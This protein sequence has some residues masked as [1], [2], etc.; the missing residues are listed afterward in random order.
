MSAKGE[1]YTLR[2]V[3]LAVVFM[4]MAIFS[5]S[6][7]EQDDVVDI[8]ISGKVTLTNT[9]TGVADITVKITGDLVGS[10]ITDING[11]YSFNELQPGT[12]FLEPV[13]SDYTFDPDMFGIFTESSAPDIDFEAFPVP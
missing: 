12:Y 1:S 6:C 9:T 13:D 3:W 10:A 11:L 2:L 4:L 5:L 7:G 8:T